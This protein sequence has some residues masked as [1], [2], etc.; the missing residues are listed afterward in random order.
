[1]L[2]QT[3]HFLYYFKKSNAY[4]TISLALLL[5]KTNQP[6]ADKFAA[7]SLNCSTN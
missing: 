2:I 6:A 4:V 3:K 7:T 1:M 5:T